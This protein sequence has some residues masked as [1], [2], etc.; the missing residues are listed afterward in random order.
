M[1]LSPSALQLDGIPALLRWQVSSKNSTG[2]ARPLSPS[3][4]TADGWEAFSAISGIS[5]MVRKCA[6]PRASS[7]IRQAVTSSLPPI[8]MLT[9]GSK[10]SVSFLI[11]KYN[12]TRNCQPTISGLIFSSTSQM[13]SEKTVAVSAIIFFG[14]AT[15]P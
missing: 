7:L 12:K 3:R 1:T 11:S 14:F 10:R 6:F 9:F 5:A 8:L 13:L 4:L 2:T 15:F